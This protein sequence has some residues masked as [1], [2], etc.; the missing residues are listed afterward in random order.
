MDF[1]INRSEGLFWNE[2]DKEWLKDGYEK[3]R[4]AQ[5]K[6]G[7]DRRVIYRSVG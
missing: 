2:L 5:P 1:P 4:E 3:R 7:G 6:K